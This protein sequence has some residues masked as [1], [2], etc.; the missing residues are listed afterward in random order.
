MK[1][2]YMADS[3]EKPPVYCKLVRVYQNCFKNFA[4]GCPTSDFSGVG[5]LLWWCFQLFVFDQLGFFS[6]IMAIQLMPVTTTA[7]G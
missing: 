4:P 1:N 2:S 6:R 7:C 3:A 5:G